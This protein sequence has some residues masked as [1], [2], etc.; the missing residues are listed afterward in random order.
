M[1]NEDQNKLAL[2]TSILNWDFAGRRG[3]APKEMLKAKQKD[4]LL[5]AREFKL[6]DEFEDVIK[7]MGKR[8]G[9]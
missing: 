7:R 1:S 6:A 9:L 8:M 2:M 5:F 4:L 3:G